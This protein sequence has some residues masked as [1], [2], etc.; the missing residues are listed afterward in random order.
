MVVTLFG[1]LPMYRRVAE[2]SPHG[3]GSLS[4]LERLL[5][6]WPSKLFVLALLG[7]VATGF[8]ITITLS[9]ADATAH[10]VE[11]PF[12]T[13]ALHGQEVWLT[14]VL[15]VLL[16]AVFLKGFNEAIGIAVVLVVAYLGLNVVVVAD[17][18]WHVAQDP[19]TVTD[20]TDA[21][22]AAHASPL[23]MIGASL[24]VF[25]A[26]ALGLSGFE[27]GVVVMPLVKGDPSDTDASPRAGSAT[28]GSC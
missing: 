6:Y 19:G 9:A 11:N 25:P 15:L 10:L 21:V 12:L 26:L 13:E 14:L 5:S 28:P 27:T 18:L 17:G 3:D 2:E 22:T 7:F 24:L 8:I 16:G 20:W 1:A 4:M 23:A